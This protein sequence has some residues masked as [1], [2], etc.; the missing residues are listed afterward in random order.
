MRDK[1]DKYHHPLKGAGDSG[2]ENP[3]RRQAGTEDR[4]NP[5]Y[6]DVEGLPDRDFY[7]LIG[8]RIGRGNSTVHHSLWADTAAG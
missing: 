3:H 1:Q 7:Y 5:I 2:E 6:L 4:R 8:L